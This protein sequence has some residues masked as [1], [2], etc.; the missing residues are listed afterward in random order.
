MRTAKHWFSRSQCLKGVRSQ[1]T[2]GTPEFCAELMK[3]CRD[4]NSEN[5]PAAKEIYNLKYLLDKSFYTSRQKADLLNFSSTRSAGTQQNIAV[6]KIKETDETVG[7]QVLDVHKQIVHINA[8]CD[9]I[10]FN[11]QL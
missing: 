3:R 7:C 9:N 6:I 4:H 5:S 11:L 2:D 1:I 8:T 10:E